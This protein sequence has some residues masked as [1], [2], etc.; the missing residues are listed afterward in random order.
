MHATTNG[1][2]PPDRSGNGSLRICHLGKFYPPASGG[3]ETHVRTLAQAQAALGAEVRVLC[4]NHRDRRGQDVTWKSWATTE[5]VDEWD[6]PVRVTRLGKRASLVRF[7]F[8]LGLPGLLHRLQQDSV[9]LLHLHVPN[10]TML[11]ALAAVR[12]R[13]PVVVTYHSDVIRQVRLAQLVRP[14]E[15]LVFGKAEALFATSPAYSAGSNLL[16]H[17]REKL[18]VLPFGI[19]LEPFLHP[20]ACAL[21][22]A[23]KLRAEHGQPLWLTVGRLVYYK[24]LHNAIRALSDVPGK[25]LV[26]GTGP[27][28]PALRQLAAEAGVAGRVVW[29]RHLSD[30]DLIGAYHAATA[31]WFPSN[32]RSEAFGLVQAEAMASGCP[33]INSAIPASGVPWV[34]RHDESGLTVPVDD[35]AALAAAANR[36]LT[37]PGLRERLSRSG[38]ERACRD[39]DHR[40]MARRSLEF[41]HQ[42]L[43][44]GDLDP[45]GR[46]GISVG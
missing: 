27:L 4:V 30:P 36:L 7:E 29:R 42:A 16:Q 45:R 3:M 14:F 2:A 44:L 39:F 33:V 37:E 9:D 34:S 38:R 24:G 15:H 11:V 40:L 18:D 1:V 20:D 26:V 46:F 12:P 19:D 17:Y 21:E 28:E 32:A 5:T 8:C 43:R 6:G 13:L 10:P 23:G 25:L 22:H 31:L 41:Y 35:P